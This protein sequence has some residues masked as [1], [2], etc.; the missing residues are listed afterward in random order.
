MAERSEQLFAQRVA[1]LERLRAH[2]IDPYP[3]TFHRTHTAAEARAAFE[4]AESAGRE[5]G[6]VVTVAGRVGVPRG[7][8][9]LTF[10]DLRDGSGRIQAQFTRDHLGAERYGL[11][12][13]LDAGDFLGVRGA[14]TR[15]RTGEITVL[16]DDF[17]VL[18]KALQPPP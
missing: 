10:L 11:L 14:L 12:R 7:F 8:G 1:K 15:T 16:A 5:T 9:R 6:P 3:A 13:D 2:G 4:A 18:A 17:T